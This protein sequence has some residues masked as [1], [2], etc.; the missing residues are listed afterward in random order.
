MTCI[1]SFVVIGMKSFPRLEK[2]KAFI[3]AKLLWITSPSCCIQIGYVILDLHG[4]A[5]LGIV[6]I[7]SMEVLLSS[8][9]ELVPRPVGPQCFPTLR[10]GIYPSIFL[11]NPPYLM[12]CPLSLM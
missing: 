7:L 5:L 11:N 10:F 3:E 12:M 4:F 2:I 8:L 9:I 1:Y 6:D